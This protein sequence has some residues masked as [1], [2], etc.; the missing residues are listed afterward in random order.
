MLTYSINEV[1]EF[2]VQI[3]KNGYAFYHEASKRKDLEPKAKEFIEFLRDEELNHEKTFLSLRGEAEMQDLELS[4]DW[5][6]VSEYLKTIVD[7]RIFNSEDSAIKKATGAKDLL[8]IID[9][10]ISFEKDTLLYFHAIKDGISNPNTNK[11]LR[12]IINE[13]VSHVLKLSDYKKTLTK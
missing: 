4:A 11:V 1:I 3:E 8:E 9:F 12:R 10:A 6:L 13:E 2:A 7:S 5:E